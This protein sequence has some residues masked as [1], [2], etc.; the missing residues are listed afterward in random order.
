MGN[1]KQAVRELGLI[2]YPLSHSFSVKYF[3]EKF[4]KEGIGDYSYSNFPIPDIGDLE[5][6]LEEHP[7]LVG[8]NVTIPYKQQ[9]IPY[10]HEV[11]PE[12][13]EVG[14][15]NTLAITRKGGKTRLKGYNTDV[16]GFRESLIPLL[17]DRHSHALVLGTGG[18]ARAVVHVLG[19]LGISFRYV[20]RKKTPGNLE[21]GDLC[22]SVIRNHHLIINTTPVGTFPDTSSFPDI[23][24]DILTPEH[25]L[26][27]LVYN[28]PET[29][30]LRMGKQKGAK[31]CNGLEML[32]LQAERSWEIWTA[33]DR[34]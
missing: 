30:F 29:S 1:P 2:G 32:Q 23:P 9:V 17:G 21:Y 31:T 16:Y 15:V 3:A 11:D 25:L 13:R 18:A 20:S 33:V 4:R 7:G 24:Y 26:Y 6:L 14:A 12:A 10:L 8:L 34:F 5:G 19:Q 28:P 22:L 27:D